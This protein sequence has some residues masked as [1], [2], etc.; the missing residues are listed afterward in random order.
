MSCTQKSNLVSEFLSVGDT[1]LELELLTRKEAGTFLGIGTV[2][3][4]KTVLRSNHLPMFAQIRTPAGVEMVD[5]QIVKRQVDPVHGITLDFKMAKRYE[6]LM[7]WMVHTVRNRSNITDWS[8]DQFPSDATLRLEIKPITRTFGTQVAHGFVYQYHYQSASDPIYRLMDRGSWEIGGEPA[9]N[10]IWFRCGT[11][12]S[13]FKFENN[14]QFYST[15]W[16]LP[17]ISNPNIFQFQPFQT[18]YQGFTFTAHDAGVLLTYTTKTAHIRTLLEKP[19]KMQQLLH[20]HEHC[21]DL[22]SQLSSF[23]MEV[24]WVPG[25]TDHVARANLYERVR[26]VV[27]D[28]LHADVG[29]R[30]E[31]ITTR[32]TLEEWGDADLQDYR[33]RCLPML[34]EMGI[35]N[36]FI[37][38]H[39]RNNMNVYGISNMCC[40]VDLKVAESVGEANLKQF[41]D[42]AKAAG[43][44]VEMWGNTSL[45]TM[46]LVTH[47]R[48]GREKHLKF[49]PIEGSAMAALSKSR[50]A[51]VRNPSNAIE[52]DHYTPVFAVMN[53][54][55][56]V[57][58]EYWLSSWQYAHD[59]IGLG[60]IFLDSSFNLSSDKFHY[61]Y[62][63]KDGH[64]HGATID[65]LKQFTCRPA[66]EPPSTILSQYRAHLELMA[67]MQ[68]M[69]YHYAGEDIGVFGIHRSGPPIVTRLNAL[70]LWSDTVISF[71]AQA[72]REAG[73][74]PQDIYFRGLAYRQM[75]EIYWNIDSGQVCFLH[76][77]PQSDEQRPNAWHIQL[78]K[79]FNE[80]SPLMFNRQILDEESGVLYTA[81]NGT[82]IL[83]SFA[84]PTLEIGLQ[85]TVTDVTTGQTLHGPVLQAEPLHIYRIELQPAHAPKIHVTGDVGRITG[86]PSV[87]K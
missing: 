16:F 55:D 8:Q 19:H 43:M 73:R 78:L 69:G 28:A 26:D 1:G 61:I 77:P 25:S 36:V 74:D 68:K 21:A 14:N 22:S 34:K 58:Q 29:M 40:T 51:F 20:V 56:P 60:G 37:S 44:H 84:T 30:R 13:I 4:G 27:H 31:R 2:R 54:R 5:F 35:K 49:L 11:A 23:P 42:D 76:Q 47:N 50:D 53:L 45:S 80:V 24:L 70:H 72:I 48:N 33:K 71:D 57:V 83:W 9:N 62:N 75:W 32:S 17:G 38:N 59:Q 15:E 10:E 63:T 39:F 82:Q 3:A 18:Q 65:Q 64:G 6:N 79:H 12:P 86:S 67:Q 52:A 7:E 66:E 41:C 46:S 81:P 87:A 85:K